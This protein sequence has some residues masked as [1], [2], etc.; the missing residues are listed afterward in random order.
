MLHMSALQK[1]LC[2]TARDAARC[3][4]GAAMWTAGQ[5][6]RVLAP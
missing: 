1:A 5:R 2:D 6:S 3:G 4:L